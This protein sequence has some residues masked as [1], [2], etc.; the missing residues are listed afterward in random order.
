MLGFIKFMAI[1]LTL[2]DERLIHGS[3]TGSWIAYTKPKFLVVAHDDSANDPTKKMILEMAAPKSV[4]LSILSVEDTG[5]KI[6][7]GAADKGN[8]M[9]LLH[10]LIDL[11]KLS[12]MGVNFDVVTLSQI[13]HKPDREE[14]R[15]DYGVVVGQDEIKILRGMMDQGV[16]FEVRPVPTYRVKKLKTLLQ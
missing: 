8:V 10:N 2:V 16:E 4:S 1:I 7:S 3:V 12:E 5:K 15:L 13:L 11:Y 14:R 6:L 9:L